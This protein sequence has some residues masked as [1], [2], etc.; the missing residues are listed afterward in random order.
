MQSKGGSKTYYNNRS[1]V[2]PSRVIPCLIA[3]TTEVKVGAT[4]MVIFDVLITHLSLS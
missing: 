4:K 2:D 3:S 1:G